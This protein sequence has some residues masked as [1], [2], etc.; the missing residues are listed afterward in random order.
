MP[1]ADA[2]LPSSCC[3]C[4]SSCPQRGTEKLTATDVDSKEQ[5]VHQTDT[6]NF[7]EQCRGSHGKERRMHYEY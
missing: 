5:R 1:P 6:K 4:S 7:G 3:C 2:V